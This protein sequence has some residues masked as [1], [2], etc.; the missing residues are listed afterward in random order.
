[1]SEPV[2]IG[3]DLG[4]TYLRVGVY[5][6][7]HFEII[8]NEEYERKTPC[9]VAL[10]GDRWVVG[11]AAKCRAHD[12]I[13]NTFFSSKRMICRT[14][15][16]LSMLLERRH[17]PFQILNKNGIA[18]II[19]GGGKLEIFPIEISAR[20]LCKAREM[21]EQHLHQEVTRAVITVPAGFTDEQKLATLQARQLAGL[22]VLDLITDPIAAAISYMYEAIDPVKVLL[23][24]SVGGGSY[25]VSI[26]SRSDKIEKSDSYGSTDLGGQDMD[27][28]LFEFYSAKLNASKLGMKKRQSYLFLQ[29]CVKAKE[30]L[31]QSEPVH[32]SGETLDTDVSFVMSTGRI[33][34]IENVALFVSKIRESLNKALTKYKSIDRIVLVGGCTRMACIQELLHTTGV[35]VSNCLDMDEAIVQGAA[36]HAHALCAEKASLVEISIPLPV[37]SS[38]PS[39]K[40]KKIQS[41]L[42]KERNDAI[43][44]KER[45]KNMNEFKRLINST[46]KELTMSGTKN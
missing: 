44:K 42:Q 27:S 32:F 13:E 45:G 9:F 20:I 28:A 15:D 5:H 22:Q 24:V 19:A 37:I 8:P 34:T 46:R 1:M 36:R 3:I 43:I 14:Y 6:H 41:K 12:D 26:V 33:K 7:G 11:N 39:K 35:R 40:N 23:V 21:A 25:D 17:W 31:V 4:T 30:N 16:D 38:G 10:V 18:K 2:A 29:E